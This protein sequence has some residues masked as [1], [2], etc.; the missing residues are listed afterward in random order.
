MK[1]IVLIISALALFAACNKY[2]ETDVPVNEDEVLTDG[3]T[4]TATLPDVLCVSMSEDDNDPE[5]RT[6]VGGVDGKDV[7]WHGDDDIS[8]ITGNVHVNYVAQGAGDSSVEFV[9]GDEEQ[10]ALELAADGTIGIYPYNPSNDLRIVKEEKVVRT[11]FPTVQTYAPNSFGKGATVMVAKNETAGADNLYFRNACG[12]LV[13]KLYGT[14]TAVRSIVLSSRSGLDKISGDAYVSVDQSKDPEVIMSDFSRTTITLDCS[15]GGEGVQLGEDKEHAT[16]FWFAMPPVTFEKG[17]KIVVTDTR[18]RTF[19]KSTAKSV[20][21]T[22]NNVQPM[23]AQEFEHNYYAS[24]DD[25]KIWYKAEEKL[26]FEYEGAQIPWFNTEIKSHEWV[27][28][29]N[30]YCVEF[31]EPLARIGED[32]FRGDERGAKLEYIVLPNTLVTIGEGAFRDSDLFHIDIPGSVNQIHQ[33]AF[34]NCQSL[35]EIV[36]EPSPSNMPLHIGYSTAAGGSQIGPFYHSPLADIRLNR[37]MIY[38]KGEYN[39][40][41]FIPDEEDEGIFAIEEVDEERSTTYLVIGGQVNTLHDFMFCNHP[42]AVLDIPGTVN[43]IGNNVFNGCTRLYHINL[44]SSPDGEALTLGYNTDGEKGPFSES[45]L[46]SISWNREINYTL[47]DIDLDA[48]NEGVFSDHEGLTSVTI[49]TQ[50]KTLTPYIF[51]DTGLTSITIPSS[52]TSIGEYAFDGCESLTSVVFEESAEPIEIK[53]QGDS[54]GPFY[55]S[56]LTNVGYNRNINYKKLDGTAFIPV[57]D[58]DGIFAINSGLKDYDDEIDDLITAKYTVSISNHIETIPDRAF[59][60]LMI[61]EITIPGTVNT[62]GNNVFNGCEDLERITFKPSLSETPLTL[63]Y[64]TDDEEDGPFL[65][66]PLTTVSLGR[67]INYVLA[68]GDLDAT[69]EGVFSDREELTSVT[70]GDQVKT[71][72]DYMFANTGFSTIELNKVRKIG[73]V[74]FWSA[75]V[76]ELTIPATLDTIEV[77]AFVNCDYLKELTFEDDADKLVVAYQ[78]VNSADWGPFYDSPLE[79]VYLGREIMYVDNAGAVFIPG[80]NNDGFFASEESVEDLEITLGDNV[81]TI[82]DYMFAGLGIQSI[83][84]PS[85]VQV[86]RWEAFSD[87]EELASLTIEDGTETITIYSQT[88]DIRS[89]GTFYDSPL[90][91]IYLG[92]EVNYQ[93][94]GTNFNDCWFGLFASGKS[95][96]TLSVTLSNN[97]KTI[98]RYMFAERPITEITIPASVTLIQNNAFEDCSKLSKVVFESSTTPLTMSYQISAFDNVGPFYQSPLSYISLDREIVPSAK[99][100]ELLKDWDM[101][102]FANSHYNDDDLRTEVH[103]GANMKTIHPWMFSG[104]R[105]RQIW[106]PQEIKSIGE[107]AFS[108]CY[109]FDGL[110][111]NHT[112]PPTLGANAFYRAGE[113]TSSKK[114]RYISVIK[115]AKEAFLAA[116][117]WKDYADIITEWTPAP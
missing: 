54:D 45:P 62:I 47:A 107:G 108:Y 93:I 17:L 82:S 3:G 110:T 4:Q 111:C 42:I 112:T 8:Y 23:A 90:K 104:V 43:S 88:F 68:S 97:V 44:Y 81:K 15:N 84:I 59:C 25:N 70:L 58:T 30:L 102:I 79:T 1:R 63:G 106:I 33:D 69:D 92:R 13:L 34:Y 26:N 87:C 103:L 24:T 39:S 16:E 66:S 52:I 71:L 99:Y 75:K 31:Y 73:K 41:E 113:D 94:Y 101:G 56:P 53:G 67:E 74:A 95:V 10:A 86:I 14:D 22:R 9:Q 37:E 11:T 89:Y 117:G 40:E 51:A 2:E 80:Q 12:Y 27:E 46:S 83:T 35:R 85:S 109:I 65:D 115:G 21:I 64:N 116:D 5:T 28:E 105:V 19:V 50:V 6:Y 7:F 60:N 48:N 76:E 32:A 18:D 29:K 72:S 55:D 96:D 36:F 78:N 77:N 91:N 98:H 20:A 57:D 49:G 100:Q 114:I 38:R 61:R